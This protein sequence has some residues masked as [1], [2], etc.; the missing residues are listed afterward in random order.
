MA[1]WTTIVPFMALT[2]NH[3]G[4]YDL[5]LAVVLET[6]PCIRARPSM[7]QRTPTP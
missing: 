3:A 7:R 1:Y 4:T 6:W 2:P 5:D